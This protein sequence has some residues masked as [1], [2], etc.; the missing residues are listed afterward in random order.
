[1]EGSSEYIEQA[2]EDSRQGVALQLGGWTR[3]T[4]PTV[5][6]VPVRKYLT[7]PRI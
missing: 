2:V 5:K 1:M 7:Q 3:L 6:M 4:S